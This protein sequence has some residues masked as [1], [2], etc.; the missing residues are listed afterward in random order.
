MEQERE[1][2]LCLCPPGDGAP[3]PVVFPHSERPQEGTDLTGEWGGAKSTEKARLPWQVPA[4]WAGS[5]ERT[6][7]GHARGAQALEGTPFHNSDR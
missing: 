5:P 2:T 6:E 3:G 1:D 4:R 7:E